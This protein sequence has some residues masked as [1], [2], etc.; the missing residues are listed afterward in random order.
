MN[1]VATIFMAF[2]VFEN[3][4]ASDGIMNGTKIAIEKMEMNRYIVH[5]TNIVR[6]F[7]VSI[8]AKNSTATITLLS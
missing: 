7:P 1:T 5:T 8:D 4:P 6:S 2:N 3:S